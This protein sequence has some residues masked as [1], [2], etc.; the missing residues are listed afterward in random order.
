VTGAAAVYLAAARANARRY[1]GYRA[2]T[3]AGA[4][5]NTVFGLIKAYVLL[6]V[7][8]QQPH[9]GGYDAT[10]AVTFVFVGQALI[11]SMALF[12]GGLDLPE[13]V[14]GGAIASDLARP[15]SFQ[16]WW[17]AQDAGRAVTQMAFRGVPPM[18]VAALVFTLR[19][20]TR[21]VTW[22]AF[23]LA[24]ACG[25]GVS[26]GLRYLTAMSAFWLADH[27][28]ADYLYMLTTTFFSGLAVPLVLIPGALGTAARML[29]FAAMLQVP[30]DVFL[31]VR[32]GRT[33]ITG[34]AFSVTWLVILAAVGA[35]VTARARVR[36]VVHGG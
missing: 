6:Q 30:A 36:V 2:A 28:G 23:A 33:V 31:G 35:V 32:H 7:W 18:L 12:G 9:I 17:A 24:A 25:W 3:A 19:V 13:R 4:F 16:G 8:R 20:P 34:L 26:F 29:P 5:T 22:V 11:A 10:A 1:A 14:R 27:R 15:V 21:P